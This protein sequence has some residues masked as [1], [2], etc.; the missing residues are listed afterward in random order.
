MNCN[1]TYDHYE[2]ILKEF[3][4]HGYMS[5]P[6]GQLN[7][8]S[9]KQLFLRHDV[10]F[11]DPNLQVFADLEAENGLYATYFF[12]ITAEHYNA[13]SNSVQKMISFLR[14]KGHYIGWHV[15][16][17]TFKSKDDMEYEFDKAS[18]I[19]GKLD[20][21]SF[22][23]PNQTKY[24]AYL[25]ENLLLPIPCTYEPRFVNG[26]IY[27]S[28]SSM[29]WRNGCPCDDIKTWQGRSCQLLTHKLVGSPAVREAG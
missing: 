10:D 8:W 15:D 1:F 22:H 2:A 4:L 21:Y 16:L 18:S 20:A 25:D 14:R 29:Q 11:F 9:T 3:Q 6:F 28:D 26:I 19:L 27:R 17:S 23:L 7:P 13:A 12:L 5:F 24:Q